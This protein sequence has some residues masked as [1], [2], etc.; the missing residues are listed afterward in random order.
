MWFSWFVLQRVYD[1]LWDGQWVEHPE[2]SREE[3]VVGL[4]VTG[5]VLE[6]LL[7]PGLEVSPFLHLGVFDDVLTNSAVGLYQ[8]GTWIFS[9]DF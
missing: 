6:S 7:Q 8:A 2:A 1:D 9:R 3:G 4:D 5:K